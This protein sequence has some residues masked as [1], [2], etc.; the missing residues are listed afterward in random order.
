MI[1]LHILKSLLDSGIGGM[2]IVKANTHKHTHIQTRKGSAGGGVHVCTCPRAGFSPFAKVWEGR[3]VFRWEGA[4][5]RWGIA[6]S[7]R[8]STLILL[9][10]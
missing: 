6:S 4:Q 1:M 10:K 9:K 8:E 7:V 3:L 5:I 2:A